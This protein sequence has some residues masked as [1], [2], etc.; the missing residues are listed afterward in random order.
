[1]IFIVSWFSDAI[2]KVTSTECHVVRLNV[3]CKDFLSVKMHSCLLISLNRG[4]NK[5][6]KGKSPRKKIPQLIIIFTFNLFSHRNRAKIGA[7]KNA[8]VNCVLGPRSVYNICTARDY[9]W[10]NGLFSRNHSGIV[11]SR[12]DEWKWSNL[13]GWRCGERAHLYIPHIS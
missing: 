13:R 3:H 11:F 7:G 5:G 1:M 12:A 2:H 8:P 10:I 6:R 9:Q 4:C